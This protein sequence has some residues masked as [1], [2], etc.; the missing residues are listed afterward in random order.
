MK[1]E[2]LGLAGSNARLLLDYRTN[3]NTENLKNRDFQ[4]T[5]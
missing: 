2:V 5:L 3:I 4:M 1:N